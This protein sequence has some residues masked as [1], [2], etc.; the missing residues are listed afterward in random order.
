MP[1]RFDTPVRCMA[2][3]DSACAIAFMGLGKRTYLFGR[4]PVE[5][6]QLEATSQAVYT[7]ARHYHHSEGIVEHRD[8]PE[9]LR[10]RTLVVLPALYPDS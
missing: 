6:D 4:L 5:L 2:V 10:S 8:R 3:C 1:A 9:L 7:C